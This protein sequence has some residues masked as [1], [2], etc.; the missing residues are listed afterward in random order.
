MPTHRH[1]GGQVVGGQVV[2]LTQQ[3]VAL[4]RNPVG[5]GSKVGNAVKNE[6]C[7]QIRFTRFSGRRSLT[8]VE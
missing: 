7:L 2:P 8:D 5:M 1:I 6:S 4:T 3:P